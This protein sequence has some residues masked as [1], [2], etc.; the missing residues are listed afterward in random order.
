VAPALARNGRRAPPLRAPVVEG[1]LDN[2]LLMF[3]TQTMARVGPFA[4]AGRFARRR[5]LFDNV[6]PDMSTRVRRCA[7]IPLPATR[8][9]DACLPATD[10]K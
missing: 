8:A 3:Y 4:V 9:R 5:A 6:D 10:R 2:V 7:R 1:A